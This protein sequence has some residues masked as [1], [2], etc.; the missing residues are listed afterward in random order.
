M[1]CWYTRKELALRTSILYSGL[2]LAQAISGLLAYAIFDNMEGAAGLR[3]WQ[4]LFIIEALMSV[5]CGFAM[6]II[7]PDYPYSS[8]GS[9]R[10]TMGVDERRL[11]VAR[12]EADRVT[13]SLDKGTVWNGLKI[14]LTDIKTYL[15]VSIPQTLKDKAD[16]NRCL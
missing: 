9:Q 16:T 14:A 11:A 10:W 12:I 8:T 3:G 15:F 4:W 5:A 13:G 1:S 6:F 7:L 2:V